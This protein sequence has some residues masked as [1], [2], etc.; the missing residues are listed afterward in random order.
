MNKKSLEE[1]GNPRAARSLRLS[2]SLTQLERWTAR[3]SYVKS[4]SSFVG[5]FCIP[6]RLS[7]LGPR[8]RSLVHIARGARFSPKGKV[9]LSC[10][11]ALHCI[12][13]RPSS[14]VPRPSSLVP[15]P[16]SLVPRPSS[17][18]PRPSSLVPRPSSLV[19]RP[20]SLVP[21]PSSLLPDVVWPAAA[22][23]QPRARSAR[24]GNDIFLNVKMGRNVR[25]RPSSLVPRYP[26]SVVISASSGDVI[27]IKNA[28]SKSIIIQLVF[29]KCFLSLRRNTFCL[30][31]A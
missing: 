8:A 25:Q 6:R 27:Q 1:P 3:I 10:R 17:L 2:P 31:D 29:Q 21:R 4:N 9:P 5:L 24:R 15:R 20:S 28:I 23:R 30:F 14:L 19:P 13:L 26:S 12:P 18:V 16:S 7:A 22:K 11:L